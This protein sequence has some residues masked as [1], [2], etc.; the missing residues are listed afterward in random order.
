MD[1]FTIIRQLAIHVNTFF[2]TGDMTWTC[3]LMLCD[4]EHLPIMLPSESLGRNWNV[5]IDCWLIMIGDKEGLCKRIR[6]EELGMEIGRRSISERCLLQAIW[7]RAGSRVHQVW[8]HQGQA[9][10]L[11]PSPHT[12]L[13]PF[14]LQEEQTLLTA[15]SCVHTWIVNEGQHKWIWF[16]SEKDVGL[17]ICLFA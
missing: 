1:K 4:N 17:F 13:R 2:S 11:R 9:G 15:I 7:A 3:N 6:L 5:L 12:L 14:A 8:C 16:I 10:N